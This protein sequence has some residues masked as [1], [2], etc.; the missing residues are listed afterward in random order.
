MG[1]LIWGEDAGG[2]ACVG[3]HEIT[4]SRSRAGDPGTR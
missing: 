1:L 3:G 4:R 2:P